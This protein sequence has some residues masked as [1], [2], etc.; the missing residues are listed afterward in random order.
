MHTD[1][2]SS[3]VIQN[4]SFLLYENVSLNVIISDQGYSGQVEKGR[5]TWDV[6]CPLDGSD[7]LLEW[8]KE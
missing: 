2:A 6:Q 7:V 5:Q 8:S 1:I 3:Q 4:I